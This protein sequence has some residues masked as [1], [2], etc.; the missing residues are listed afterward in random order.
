MA[1]HGTGANPKDPHPDE[2]G[3]FHFHRVAKQFHL[4]RGLKPRGVLAPMAF[5]TE[6]V[7]VGAEPLG[8]I[9]GVFLVTKEAVQLERW[10]MEMSFF[11]AGL[12][13]VA[14]ATQAKLHWPAANLVR[15][16]SSMRTV[17]SDAARLGA[18]R[19]VRE[20]GPVQALLHV[21]VAGQAELALA[22]FH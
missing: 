12:G 1:L 22:S 16:S 5:Q 10:P 8:T 11:G 15:I 17:T 21:A 4:S 7:N 14:M 2:G 9:T 6:F 20:F 3:R 18:Q 19:S 13:Q